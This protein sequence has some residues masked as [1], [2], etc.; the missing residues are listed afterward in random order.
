VLRQVTTGVRVNEDEVRGKCIGSSS[1]HTG[2]R[3]EEFTGQQIGPQRSDEEPQDE[4]GLGPT[5]D[6]QTWEQVEQVGQVVGQG[7]V[8]VEDRIAVA[9]VKIGGPARI[10]SASAEGVAQLGGA[11]DVQ[12][13]IC[14]TRESGPGEER[15][16]CDEGE[17]QNQNDQ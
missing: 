1:Q 5:H 9:V 3:A 4:H 12:F 15:S 2:R 17:R 11:V 10:K 8:V 16:R 13:G 14:L 6:V 7:G